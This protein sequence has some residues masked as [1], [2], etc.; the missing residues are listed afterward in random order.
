MAAP[1]ARFAPQGL[2][3]D[4]DSQFWLLQTAGWLGITIVN[5]FSLTLWYNEPEFRYIAHNVLQSLLGILISWPMR[6]IFR[7]LWERPPVP[8]FAYALL[9]VL[10]FSLLWSLVRLPLF[11]ALSGERDL[12]GDFGG[13]VYPSFFIF[14]CWAALYHGIK[15]YQLLQEEHRTLLKLKAEQQ[16][17]QLRLSE[18]QSQARHAQL[19]LLRYQLNPHF[20]FNTLNSMSSLVASGQNGKAQRMIVHLSHFL[21]YSLSD[22][23]ALVVRLAK[24]L[25]ALHRYMRIEQARFGE[26]LSMSLDVSE[27]AL[28]CRIPSM[29]LQPLVENALKHAIAPSERG[30]TIR[31]SARLEDGWLC[32]AVEDSGPHRA[33][34][35]AASPRG[36]GVGLRNTR[37]RLRAH[38]GD[39]F[40]MQLASSPLGGAKVELLVPGERGDGALPR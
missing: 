10:L 14:G 21:R 39:R 36:A 5:H 25:E 15:Y 19:R 18:A 28:E 40:G 1:E 27:E 20:L 30:G 9:T 13:W 12:W 37:Q 34:G 32:L 29:L 2:L 4:R 16:Q 33:A 26:R 22:E 17:E 11:M 6:P 38:Y 8:R 24:D 23:L 7:A 35:D 31:I 3:A